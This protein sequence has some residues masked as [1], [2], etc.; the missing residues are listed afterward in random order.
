[1]LETLHNP[2][3]RPVPM[4]MARPMDLDLRT[5]KKRPHVTDLES[6]TPATRHG[7]DLG[8]RKAPDGGN[9]KLLRYFS[10]RGP[11]R[12]PPLPFPPLSREKVL[13]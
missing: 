4:S 5:S 1:M 7:T 11:S 2:I 12:D 9:S 8:P 13:L 3:A 10:Y 6:S